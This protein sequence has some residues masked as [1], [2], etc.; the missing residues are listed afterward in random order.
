MC[1]QYQSRK[2]QHTW[3]NSTAYP[4]FVYIYIYIYIYI[5][6]IHIL[7]VYEIVFVCALNINL[8]RGNILVLIRLLIQGLYICMYVCMDMKLCL[9]VHSI[10]IWVFFIDSFF[11]YLFFFKRWVYKSDTSADEICGHQVGISL[12]HD[13]LVSDKTEKETEK[14]TNKERIRREK[15][16]DVDQEEA[17][18]AVLNITSWIV[19]NGYTLV[20]NFNEV[21][22]WGHW[23]PSTL[24]DN[25]DWYS[26][27]QLYSLQ[28]LSWLKLGQR[29]SQNKTYSLLF[30]ELWDKNDYG[31]NILDQKITTPDDNNPSDDELA[32][33]S[34]MAWLRAEKVSQNGEE[35]ANVYFPPRFWQSIN[36]TISINK[37]SKPSLWNIIYLSTV[38]TINSSSPTTNHQHHHQHHHQD[39]I[40]SSSSSS[41]PSFH[42]PLYSSPPLPQLWK[43]GLWCLKS[44]PTELIDWPIYNSHRFDLVWIL[45]LFF[46][47]LLLLLL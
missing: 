32:W 40:P 27:R 43:D 15:E 37:V 9:C 47:L 5:Y 18:E 3:F 35:N 17:K 30:D 42:D 13:L 28:L 36:R 11:L 25:P 24:N 46:G 33:L 21:T 7:Y 38:A 19:E 22:T 41:S 16:G 44:W 14:E 4:G 34:Y 31:M 12:Y 20:S 1:T 23:E 29:L 45:L 8:G 39:D 26:E 10:S 6:Y 2:G